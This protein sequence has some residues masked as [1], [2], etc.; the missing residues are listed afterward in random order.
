MDRC[1]T[2]DSLQLTVNHGAIFIDRRVVDLDTL[3]IVIR[4]IVG[5]QH[6]SCNIRNILTSVTFTSDIDLVSFHAESI[7]E[8]LPETHELS[9]NVVLVIDGDVSRRESSA[10]G[11]IDVN[12]VGEVNPAV[13]VCLAATGTVL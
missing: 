4:R 1:I 9:S 8:V 2:A 12:H 10:H 3:N 6:T 11:L 7:N 5:I 13:R